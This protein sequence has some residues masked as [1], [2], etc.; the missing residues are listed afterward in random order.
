MLYEDNYLAHFGITGQRW[1]VR[2]FQNKD[3]TLTE[4]GKKRYNNG[5]NQKQENGESTSQIS[6]K[7][8]EQ[9][10]IEYRQGQKRAENDF[11]D[12]DSITDSVEREKRFGKLLKEANEALGPYADSTYPGYDDRDPNIDKQAYNIKLCGLFDQKVK[13]ICDPLGLRGPD[14]ANESPEIK[15]IQDRMAENIEKQDAL[16][17][18][19]KKEYESK[20]KYDAKDP[21]KM[22]RKFWN[23][24]GVMGLKKE[25][26]EMEGK[27]LPIQ[28]VKELGLPPTKEYLGYVYPFIWYD[29][30]DGD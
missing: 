16:W 24:P 27:E 29:P 19:F 1:G 13:R 7:T 10:Q 26:A 23:E 3:G 11:T 25:Y 2:R 14:Y 8:K 28:I 18:K 15:K 17:E 30:F 9:K 4:A 21:G 22:F 20:Y 6:I 12:A 5:D